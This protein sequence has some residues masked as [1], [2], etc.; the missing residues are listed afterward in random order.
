MSS[1]VQLDKLASALKPQLS[2]FQYVIVLMFGW[3][4]QG[5]R[6]DILVDS[7]LIYI[8]LVQ[9]ISTQAY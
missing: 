9:H 6:F 2:F 8:L 4:S 3:P 5:P 1:L 7:I